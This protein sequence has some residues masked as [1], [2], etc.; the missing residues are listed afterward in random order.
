MTVHQGKVQ[1][2]AGGTVTVA[3]L[4]LNT[5]DEVE[6]I[7][8]TADTPTTRPTMEEVRRRLQGSVL[9][10]DRPYEPAAPPEEWDAL[11]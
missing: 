3:G 11:R 4:P 5:G 1:V 8:R 10:Y 2:A 9:R 7:V 6:V